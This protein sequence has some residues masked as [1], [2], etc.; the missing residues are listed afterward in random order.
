MRG[1]FSQFGTVVRLRLSRS[2]KTGRS[3][4][5][6]FIEFESKEVAKI[7][8]NTMNKY[9]LCGQTL[10]SELLPA[11]KVHE[12]MFVGANKKFKV[13][14][15]RLIARQRHN[16]PKTGKQQQKIVSRLL[17]KE[18]K[19]REKLKAAGIDYDF[20]GYAGSVKPAPKRRKFSE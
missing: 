3:K 16:E 11:E 12:R 17:K 15:W 6:A 14:P 13:M 1:F 10:S 4:H 18:A 5:Y 20:S 9:I 7:V 2:K 19:K 8:A